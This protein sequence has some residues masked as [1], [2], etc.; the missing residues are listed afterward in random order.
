MNA[1]N[2]VLPQISLITRFHIVLSSERD[3]HFKA[4]LLKDGYRFRHNASVRLFALMANVTSRVAQRH[5]N[6]IR[7]R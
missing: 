2:H 1:A 7:Y 4:T 6:A 5:D 3:T